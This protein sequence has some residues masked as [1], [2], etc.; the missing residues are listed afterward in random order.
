MKNTLRAIRS[1]AVHTDS[2][3]SSHFE[4]HNF[5]D[6]FENN[7]VFN[8]T[9]RHKIGILQQTQWP[10]VPVLTI[11][12]QE[13]RQSRGGAAVMLAKATAAVV[14]GGAEVF[15]VRVG[16]SL[17]VF[18]DAVIDVK[19]AV[20]V[21]GYGVDV[22]VISELRNFWL[23]VA[24]VFI[25]RGM[26]AVG[27]SV[28]AMA[29]LLL[30]VINIAVM[31]TGDAAVFPVAKGRSAC[32]PTELRTEVN[33]V[34]VLFFVS[35]STGVFKAIT[36]GK[37]VFAVPSEKKEEAGTG[38]AGDDFLVSGFASEVPTVGSAPEDTPDNTVMTEWVKLVVDK[39]AEVSCVGDGWT[40]VM[41]T[42][43]RGLMAGGCNGMPS[44][45][46]LDM[47]KGTRL[48]LGGFVSH[49][50]TLNVAGM[51]PATTK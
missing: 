48:C 20:I 49:S 29:V 21:S 22:L 8:G 31:S 4:L 33:F 14:S 26:C 34:A 30:G 47:L 2:S 11:R 24:V 51:L 23:S 19:A 39:K 17:V 36:D 45:A 32:I 10:H 27:A 43:C 40:E 15:S 18:A 37:G 46:L 5:K 16:G 38:E 50:S 3:K 41:M 9:I 13:R 12:F 42:D 7:L 6:L 44:V 1:R 35:V 25:C 28:E